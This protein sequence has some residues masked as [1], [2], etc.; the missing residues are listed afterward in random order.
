MIKYIDSLLNSITM[1]RVVL[2][3]LLFLAF[4]AGIFSLTKV[5]FYSPVSLLISFGLLSMSCF[6]T[7]QLLSRLFHAPTNFESSIIT[8]LILFF[9]LLPPSTVQEASVTVL[10]GVIAMA[11]K[12]IFAIGKKHIFNPAAFSMFFLGLLGLGNAIW[13]IGSDV[14]LP[15]TLVVGLL[16]VRKTRKFS[17]LFVFLA[18]SLITIALFGIKNG[19][20][21]QSYLLE[22]FTSWPLLFFATVMLTEPLTMPSTRKFQMIYAALVGI[23]FGSQFEFF[24]LYST[25][26]FALIIGNLFA[27][28]VSP[29]AKLFLTLVKSH[30]IAAN[31]YEFIFSKPSSFLFK[32][33]QYL[34]WT[35]ADFW[36][37]SRG[38]RR[39][40][41]IASSPTEKE[42]KLG[43]RVADTSS[44][45]KKKLQSLDPSTMI[46]GGSLT[47]DFTL[48]EDNK[49]KLVFIAGG[50]GITPFRSMIQYLCDLK[51]PRDITL[52]YV[53]KKEE[54]I[55]YSEI[56]AQ[57]KTVIGLK[58]VFVLSDEDQIRSTWTGKKGRIDDRM[59][60]NEVTDYLH[61]TYYLS[62]PNAMVDAYKHL[63]LH[64]GVHR[65]A[66]KTDYFPGF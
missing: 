56:F 38:N 52:F 27:Y 11:S 8:T 21:L 3:G 25:P 17:L 58:T 19:V 51:E 36:P 9:L 2:Y 23:L 16:I 53:N 55:A 40:F 34:E 37:D 20:H 49:Q 42:L 48:P 1:Y 18:T 7:N 57:A 50:I 33:G 4:I 64:M 62:G 41:T 61:R 24:I 10:A 60:K 39:Y 35:I 31:T 47:G 26:E 14:L 65:R 46:V 5:L 15:F 32:P 22:A 45:F 66:I 30:K 29:K 43:I 6:V 63:L 28:I 54:E 12:Y 13:W 59:I 44:T